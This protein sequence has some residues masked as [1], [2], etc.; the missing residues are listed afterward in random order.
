MLISNLGVNK[1]DAIAPSKPQVAL[2]DWQGF[3][4]LSPNRMKRFAYFDRLLHFATVSSNGET[5]T[6]SPFQSQQKTL[7]AIGGNLFREETKRLPSHT[8]YIS[9]KWSTYDQ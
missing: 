8:L 9:E 2:D 5:L 3:Y 6:L 4:T 1:A 7:L